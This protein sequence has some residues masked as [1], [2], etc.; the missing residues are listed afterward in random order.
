MPQLRKEVRELK[1]ENDFFTRCGLVLREGKEMKFAFIA[2]HVGRFP[3]R[4]MCRRLSVSPS[5][6]Y[7]WRR[8]G[9]S[10]RAVADERLRTRIKAHHAASG[11]T[12]GSPRIR[13]DL[14]A[15]GTRISRRRVARLM[16]KQ[17]LQGRRK[18]PIPNDDGRPSEPVSGT[19][20]AQTAVLRTGTRR[21]MG[22][23]Y[24]V[25]AG[26]GKAGY[27]LPWSSTCTRAAWSATR[28]PIT[29]GPSW[30]S[31][32]STPRLPYDAQKPVSSS[33][34]TAA[35]STPAMPIATLCGV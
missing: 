23:R 25:R 30:S 27:P 28:W 19:E 29:C 34:R 35:P 6:F 10:P 11:G 32:P 22:L 26:P 7:A 17:G 2:R 4:W 15:E 31:R 12:Y 1:R 33:I 20:S 16:R 5:G 13:S 14:Q 24:L 9:S 8:R 18:T 21:R 3:T